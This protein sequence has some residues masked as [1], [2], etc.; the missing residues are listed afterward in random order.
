MENNFVTLILNNGKKHGVIFEKNTI[1]N[2]TKCELSLTTKDSQKVW[3]DLLK[4]IK[5][6]FIVNF[7]RGIK[8]T[9]S[10]KNSANIKVK[11]DKLYEI[12]MFYNLEENKFII[13]ITYSKEINESITQSVYDCFL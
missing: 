3:A 12:N 4:D 1:E 5:N 11:S 7:G 10:G 13:T 6:D 8:I 9:T 2:E